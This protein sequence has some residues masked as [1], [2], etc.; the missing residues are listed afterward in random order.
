MNKRI[1]LHYVR[2]N[3]ILVA[4]RFIEGKYTRLT[5]LGRYFMVPSGRNEGKRSRKAVFECDCGNVV[6]LDVTHVR[7]GKT[8]SC[9]C[10]HKEDIGNRA[11]RHGKSLS[12]E[13]ISWARMKQRCLDPKNN[14]YY[15]Y[16]ELGIT[17]CDRWLE[18][19][20]QGFINFLSDMGPKP[21]P[22]H[23]IERK[24]RTKGYDPDN[25][26]WATR[27]E[28]ANN[29][30]SNVMLTIN[31]ETDTMSNWCRKYNTNARLVGDRIR[32]LKWDPLKALITPP[33]P[34]KKSK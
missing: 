20:G 19:D 18:K 29:K 8:K 4:N 6:I 13:H 15:R 23:S 17:I 30:S 9:G 11:R 24:D 10:L 22:E 21:S 12:P 33:R 2:I 14:R 28:Q 3:G 5:I 1:R 26:I 32:H 25:C 31:G 16:G 27:I 34:I 7:S